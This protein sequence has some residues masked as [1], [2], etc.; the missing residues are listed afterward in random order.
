MKIATST[1][2]LPTKMKMKTLRAWMKTT[3]LTAANNKE[4]KYKHTRRKRSK[5]STDSVVI[6]TN[7]T[8]TP[9]RLE[10]GTHRT[11]KKTQQLNQKRSEKS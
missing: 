4:M 1:A 8:T 10:L 6:M 9:G 5:T 2:E 7:H 11:M 3:A